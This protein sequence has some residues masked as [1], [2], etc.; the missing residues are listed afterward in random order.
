VSL[1]VG[2]VFFLDKN[3]QPG[4]SKWLFSAQ[5]DIDIPFGR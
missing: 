1:L 3:L 5:L 4:G 2:P